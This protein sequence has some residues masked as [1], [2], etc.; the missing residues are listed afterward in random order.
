MQL[1]RWRPFRTLVHVSLLLVAVLSAQP[2]V[3][4]AQPVQPPQTPP[5]GQPQPPTPPPVAPTATSLALTEADIAGRAGPSVVLI[6]TPSGTGSGVRVAQGI[7]TNEHVVGGASRI[8][9]MRADGTRAS[10]TPVK[11]DPRSDLALLRTDLELPSVD[12]APA[13]GHRQGDP[14][15]VMGYPLSS[16]LQGSSTLTRGLISAIRTDERG[17]TEIQTD[18]AINTGNS[19]GALLNMQGRLIGV[20]Y[21]RYAGGVQGIGFAVSSEAVQALLDGPGFP[22]PSASPPGTVLLADNFA[23]RINGVMPLVSPVPNAYSFSYVEGEYAITQTNPRYPAPLYVSVPGSY[24]DTTLAVDLRLVEEIDNRL[25]LIGCRDGDHDM[26]TGYMAAMEPT[27][28]L[29]GLA[30]FT[31]AGLVPLTDLEISD[32]F[33]LGSVNNRFELTCAETQ[34]SLSINGEELFS[35]TDRSYRDGGLWIGAVAG[36]IENVVARLGN[37]VVTQR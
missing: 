24:R 25:L 29:A 11:C 2:L 37:L 15:L 10:A 4:L 3:A 1:E 31:S 7:I 13:R 22:C 27:T 30:K 14:V 35:V 8:E 28:G 34:I 23:D 26:E 21:S 32:A 19:G 6:D 20:P 36:D 33:L 9:V 16:R 17:L 18:A 5:S 12:L